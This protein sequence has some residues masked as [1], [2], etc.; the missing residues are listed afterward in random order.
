[1]VLGRSRFVGNDLQGM[2]KETERQDRKVNTRGN[3]LSVQYRFTAGRDTPHRV[4][5]PDTT[6]R[7]RHY[8]L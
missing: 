8:V 2:E 6:N 4:L 5:Q 1:M 7:A 3:F